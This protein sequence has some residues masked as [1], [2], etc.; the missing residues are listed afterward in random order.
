MLIYKCCCVILLILLLHITNT[1]NL[2]RLALKHNLTYIKVYKTKS[3]SNILY[4]LLKQN[5]ILGWHISTNNNNN[6]YIVHINRS[7]C[8][9]I[10]T[11]IKPSNHIYIKI[12]LLKKL[13]S[14]IKTSIIYLST[15]K[16]ILS[17]NEAIKSN[18][19]GILLYA[20]I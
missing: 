13:S 2:I 20:Y 9:K 11:F 19:G 16:G 5:V 6:T 4:V 10:H 15:S 1:L 7:F 3:S 18:V 17:L 12:V 8:K 14:S